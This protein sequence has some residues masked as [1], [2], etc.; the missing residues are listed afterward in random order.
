[1]C[2]TLRSTRSMI[3]PIVEGSQLY[4]AV[5]GVGFVAPTR[6]IES[7]RLKI[8]AELQVDKKFHL[9]AFERAFKHLV[10]RCGVFWISSI[11]LA[12][13]FRFRVLDADNPIL[14]AL[15]YVSI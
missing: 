9:T 13:T 2:P 1:M 6:V 14:V 11:P 4:Q 12:G 7:G 15:G 8:T 10:Q 3:A 5:S